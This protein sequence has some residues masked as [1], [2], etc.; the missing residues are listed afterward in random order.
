MAVQTEIWVRYI[1]NRLWKDN[2]FLQF[3]YNDDQYVLGGAVVH[4]P[5]PGS[6]P[7]IVKNLSSFPAASVQRTDTDVTYNLDK[8]TSNPTQIASADLMEITYDKIASVFGDHAGAL[9]ETVADDLLIK[10]A[11]GLANIITTTGAS[12]AATDP[13]QTGTRKTMTANDVKK[14]NVL[15]NKAN[16]PQQDRYLL[17]ESNMYDQLISD[18]TQT[19]YRDFSKALDEQNGSIMGKLYSFNVMQRSNVVSATSAN[20]VN[21]LGTAIG[22]TDNLVSLAWQK[23]SVARALGERKFFEQKDNPQ[24][25]GDLYSALLR[26]GGRRR[27]ATDAGVYLVVGAA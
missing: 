25:Y 7:V 4:I 5:Q 19:Q 26:M 17:L 15:F 20:A 1:M 10:W 18:L 22:A 12:A 13:N 14:L 8:Y 3:A 6:K 2:T 21:P 27:Y 16:V 9:V 24:Y 11:T 23:D